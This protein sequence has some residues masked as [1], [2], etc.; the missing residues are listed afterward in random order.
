MLGAAPDGTRRRCNQA[1]SRV[2]CQSAPPSLRS[3]RRPAAS[4][5]RAS[6]RVGDHVRVAEQLAD[7][8]AAARA[9][10]PAAAPA[11]RRPGPGSHRARSRGRR[12]RSC[13]RG[14]AARARR[15]ALGV[16]LSM[17]CSRRAPQRVV[18]H[19][20]LH[21]EHV[22]RPAGREPLR[23]GQ[24]VVARAGAHLEQALAG[25]R[26]EDLAQALARDE[27]V[28][29]L[30]PEALRVR[31]GRRVPAPPE[32]APSRAAPP[33]SPIR[34]AA[35]IRP[36]RRPARSAGC[37]AGRASGPGWSSRAPSRRAPRAGRR[38]S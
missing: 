3:T 27:R 8:D 16:M 19:L 25:R 28:R 18:E 34:R 36:L 5:R 12:R 38:G 6:A 23:H 20:L 29:R 30:H 33:S 32:R 17:P 7:H 13:R 21:V 2:K 15:R 37:G 35:G 1:C 26:L 24:R 9:S 14:R 22:E 4:A 10:P 31:A 11:A